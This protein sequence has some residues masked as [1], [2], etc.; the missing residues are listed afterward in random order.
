MS[1]INN[2]FSVRQVV[3]TM[4]YFI[5]MFVIIQFTFSESL[6]TLETLLLSGFSTILFVLINLLL[7]FKNNK[8]G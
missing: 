5:F 7:T 1:K 4:V 3:A 8:K 2:W 6:S